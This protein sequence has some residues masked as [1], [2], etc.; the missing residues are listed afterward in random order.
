MIR[1]RFAI[2]PLL[3]LLMLTSAGK[4]VD[5]EKLR[6]AVSLPEVSFIF[7]YGMNGWGEF[8]STADLGP[9]PEKIAEIEKQL[10]GDA[11][12]AER[13]C[14]LASLY[15]RAGQ[16]DKSTEFC[17]KAEALLRKQLAVCPKNFACR[18]RLAEV[19]ERQKK[20]AEAEELLRRVVEDCPDDWRAWQALG[21]FLSDKARRTLLNGMAF[22]AT[23]PDRLL[24]TLRAASPT[25]ERIASW[26]QDCKKV[27]ACFHRAIDLAPRVPEVYL[28][29]GTASWNDSLLNCGLRL[30]NGEKADFTVAMLAP[31]ARPDLRRAVDLNPKNYMCIGFIDWMDAMAD[32]YEY[33]AQN[34][35]AKQP[36]QMLDVL[37]EATRQRVR[38]HMARLAEE[39]EQSD[40][41][42]A[43]EAAE[44]LVYLRIMLLK[45]IPDTKTILR[46][47]IELDPSRNAPWEMLI[48]ALL[49]SNQ[50]EKAAE[51]CRQHLK[52]KDS[53]RNRLLLA[54]A[55]A[56]L[57]RLDKAEE[58]IRVGL[59]RE[60]D[61]FLLNLTL[62]DL[63]LIR[64]RDDDL[65]QAGQTLRKIEK[66]RHPG[67][68][69]DNR[70]TNF[71]FA[72]GIGCGLNGE[73]KQARE[74][75]EEVHKRKPQY[76]HLQEALKALD[77]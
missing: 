11:A 35:S 56:E 33:S 74:W 59:E 8:V 65:R 19:L 68:G 69:N 45:D 2:L 52:H 31:E 51:L 6:R 32:A 50:M 43:A 3:V 41:P 37:S 7:G 76:P 73:V 5:K 10:K 15:V 39:M 44:V 24:Q 20:R 22:S 4:A 26:R 54:K 75:L 70:W 1:P 13:Y 49:A 63:L 29:R 47:S 23:G 58:V 64:G 21:Q 18:L 27:D 40:K 48:A 12:D 28:T 67:T 36:E 60:P 30:Y 14:R 61:D 25:P 16:S 46:R 77:E 72:C 34:P 38:E 53:A 9:Q 71:R 62:M 17:R 42:K 66:D 55:Y 57:D